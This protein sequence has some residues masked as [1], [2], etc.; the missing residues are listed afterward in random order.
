VTTHTSAMPMAE[1]PS[2]ER[3]LAPPEKLRLTLAAT[4]VTL[5]F[6]LFC[7]LSLLFIGVVVLVQAV[8]I[9]GAAR[10]GLASYMK[11]PAD[12]LSALAGRITRSL[13]IERGASY[14]LPLPAGEAPELHRLVERIARGLEARPPDAIVIDMRANAWVRLRGYGQGRGHCTLGLGYDLLATLSQSELEA[15]I[16]HEMAHAR[17]VQRGYDGWLVNGLVRMGQMSGALEDLLASTRTGGSR[18]FTAEL[19]QPIVVWLGK[20]GS[21]LVAAYGRQDEFAADRVA[22]EQCGSPTYR[23]VLLSIDVI[24]NKSEAVH[25]RDRAAQLQRDGSFTE[26]LR[27]R[28]VPR[29]ES[30]REEMER[31][32]LADTH[33]GR[34]DTHPSLADRL[35]ALPSGGPPPDLSV[36]AITLL[37]EPDQIAS[38]LISEVERIAGE[39]ERKDTAQR[40]E[41]ARKQPKGRRV[42]AG[43]GIAA[44]LTMAGVV[45]IIVALAGLYDGRRSPGLLDA[46]RWM[47]LPVGLTA[48]SVWGYRKLRFRER[49]LLPIPTLACWQEALQS[50]ARTQPS[51]ERWE[52]LKAD[53]ASRLPSHVKSRRARARYWAEQSYQALQQCHYLRAWVTAQLSGEAE[54]DSVPGLIAQSVAA[55]YFG[56]TGKVQGALS[57]LIDQYGLGGSV[58]WA[59]G[60]SLALMEQWSAAEDYLLDAVSRRP[61]EATLWSLLGL[62]QWRQGKF[63]E[64][65]AHFRRAIER[66]PDAPSHRIMLMRISLAMGR[67]KEALIELERLEKTAPAELDVQLGGVTAHLMYG[68]VDEA[69]R[70]AALLEQ[71]HPGPRTRLRLAHAF[72]GA[73]AHD[74]AERYYASVCETGFCPEALV[75]IATI[76][77]HQRRR[78]EARARLL[79]ALDVTREV[80]PETMAPLE[81]FEPIYHGLLSLCE[82][83]H[84]CSAWTATLSMTASPLPIRQLCLLVLAPSIEGAKEHVRC[85]Y[86]AMHPGR[87]LAENIVTWEPGPPDSRPEGGVCPG[88]HHHWY[89]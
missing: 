29:D 81:L 73:S 8:L 2:T 32:A 58:S 54:A 48:A 47:T 45:A 84:G 74:L 57:H 83:V 80:I 16:A 17:L 42:T 76:Q 26:W 78:D 30:E 4:A 28:L 11:R 24:A 31:R 10:F 60:W 20:T 35:A 13:R 46:L 67:P 70:R 59:A 77:A 89:E 22:A 3:P 40:R 61:E 71:T 14:W 68:R 7:L 75:G 12:A 6:Y 86:G 65:V 52:Q 50:A 19:M 5:L 72:R 9:I 62:C 15:V 55:A 33:T 39:Q 18:F 27:G 34:F 64:A 56:E 37:K 49:Q 25:W 69:E 38:R 44:V 82:P 23:R 88:I 85:I 43:Q 41:W 66:E 79:A 21:R 1:A 87:V 36:P 63:H 51:P 53:I